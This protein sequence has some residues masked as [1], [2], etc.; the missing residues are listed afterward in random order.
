MPNHCYNELQIF[1]KKDEVENFIEFIKSKRQGNEYDLF[2]ALTPMPEELRN[3]TSPNQDEE[4]SNQLIEKYGYSNW[5]AWAVSQWGTK[6]GDYDADMSEVY[7]IGKTDKYTSTYTYSTAWSP[8]DEFLMAS[9]ADQFPTMEFHLFYDE[10]GMGF[11]GEVVVENGKIT[12]NVYEE[13]EI[14]C[15]EDGE[16]IEDEE[17]SYVTKTVKK[18]ISS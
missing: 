8:G 2:E 11:K 17:G 15:D 7:Q 16:P 12:N 6:W 10:P 1:G 3:T 5:Y 14:E 4:L 18:V 9:L 13:Y